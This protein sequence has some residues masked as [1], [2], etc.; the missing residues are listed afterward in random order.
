M[1]IPLFMAVLICAAGFV[2]AQEDSVN[3]VHYELG[4]K[5]A[6]DKKYNEAIEE[7]RK[8]LTLDP[9]HAASYYQMGL[10]WRDQKK[11]PLS[12]YNL[13]KAAKYDPKNTAVL[14]ALSET[15][16]QN[17]EPEKA[18]AS[19]RECINQEADTV[20]K[21]ADEKHARD[22]LRSVKGGA[23]DTSVRVP[24]SDT[25][26]KTAAPAP[27]PATPA[28]VTA[29][30]VKT[31]T[32]VP[33]AAAS[34]AGE[35]F[36][37]PLDIKRTESSSDPL[38]ANFLTLFNKGDYPRA[39]LEAKAVLKKK[40]GHP[41]IYYY[42]G[43]IRRDMKDPKAALIN[44]QKALDYPE[45]GVNAHYYM[46]RIQEAEKRLPEAVAAYEKFI[47]LTQDPAARAAVQKRLS[48]LLQGL[49][50]EVPETAAAAG[51]KPSPF[52]FR[53]SDAF[54]F[55]IEDT[56]HEKTGRRMLRALDLFLDERYDE[57]LNELKTVYREVPQSANADNALYDIGLV[58]AKMRLFDNAETYLAKILAEYPK[59]D[60][61]EPAALLRGHV[62]AEKGAYDDAVAVYQAYLKARP[63]TRYLSA[64]HAALGD[65]AFHRNDLRG[66]LKHYLTALGRET[67]KKEKASLQYKIGECYWR[68]GSTRGID[69]FKQAA[70]ADSTL[71]LDAAMESCF[72]LGDYYHKIKNLESAL[73]YYKLAV[74]RFPGAPSTP[75]AR[76][77]IGNIYKQG[78]RAEEAIKA[79]QQLMERHP[80][81]YWA[82]QAKWKREDA[83][84]ENEYREVLK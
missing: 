25:V 36:K 13:K 68:D 24:V 10:A 50:K 84:W 7:F 78:G 76:Y 52:R 49:R 9:G 22:M 61:A 6:A 32:H 23:V 38:L 69:Y 65:I 39:L 34:A 26:K 14:R 53:V 21:A 70:E 40:P 29:P 67:G 77:Q 66:A 43:F 15:Y 83:V 17:G 37:N 51:E 27:A 48:S 8:M 19:L 72:R 2:F 30:A 45:K 75:W 47:R 33:P 55:L 46:G 58:Y 11:Y 44:F 35:A 79:Y 80:D 60:V 82:L 74:S 4:L 62:F 31:A 71:R 41:G 20:Q 3:A 57:S 54:V 1:R 18:M 12:L 64:I 28:P 16:F 63:E 5:Y 73:K 56:L 81:D 59:G 42:G